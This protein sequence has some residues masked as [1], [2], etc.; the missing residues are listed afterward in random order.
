MLKQKTAT[1][2]RQQ[3]TGYS[4]EVDNGSKS[5]VVPKHV[6]GHSLGTRGKPSR[7]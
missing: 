3:G 7:K 4:R 6:E 1:D 5:A 2:G